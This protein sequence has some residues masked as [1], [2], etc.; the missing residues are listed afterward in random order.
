MEEKRANESAAMFYGP[1]SAA[2]DR[3]LFVENVGRLAAQTRAG[4]EKIER[5]TDDEQEF[6]K[7]TYRGGGERWINIHADSYTAI[8]RDIFKQID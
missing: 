8:V 1:D 7:I 2:A 6:A 4:V 3:S 5:I